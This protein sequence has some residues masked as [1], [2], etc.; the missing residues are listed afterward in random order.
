MANWPQSELFSLPFLYI[1]LLLVLGFA[2]LFYSRM[3]PKESTDLYT[4]NL[5]QIEIRIS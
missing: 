5:D 2:C 3:L 4:V 1:F